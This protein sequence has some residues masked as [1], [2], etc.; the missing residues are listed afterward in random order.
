M[1]NASDRILD[2]M[3]RAGTWL[4]TTAI[5][6]RVGVTHRCVQEN[7]ADLLKEEA[8]DRRD[9]PENNRVAQWRTKGPWRD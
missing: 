1:T 5:A 2:V 6:H 4:S 8:V 9:D 7:L 3:G